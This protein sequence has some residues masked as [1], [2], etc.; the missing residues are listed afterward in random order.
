M[1]Q[2][3]DRYA[4]ALFELAQ[5]QNNL[6]AIQTT[7]SDIKKL[8]V[9]LQDFRQFLNNPLLSYEERCSTLKAMFEGKVPEIV[10]QFLICITYKGRLSILKEMIT[11]FDS[12]YLIATHQMRAYVKTA[13]PINDEDKNLINQHLHDKFKQQMLTQWDTD[14]SLIGGFR[15]FVQGKIYDYSFKNQLDHF[16]QQATQPV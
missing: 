12:M 15:I 11:S 7:L 16:F 1:S 8:T 2:T 6:E 14:P 4:K 3:A 9:E 13:L 5:E 10:L